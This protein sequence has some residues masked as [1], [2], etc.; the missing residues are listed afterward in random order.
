MHV[1]CRNKDHITADTV[2]DGVTPLYLYSYL[3]GSNEGSKKIN[4]EVFR[5]NTKI[6]FRFLSFVSVLMK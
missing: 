3:V 5:K 2:M 1:C 6:P 4:F